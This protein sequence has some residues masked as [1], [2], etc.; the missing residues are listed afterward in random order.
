M[1]C[2]FMDKT[3]DHIE[4]IRC[5]VWTRLI[6]K[7]ID[8]ICSLVGASLIDFDADVNGRTPFIASDC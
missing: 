3:I 6:Y 8:D 5:V 2:E 7:M 4:L 1:L